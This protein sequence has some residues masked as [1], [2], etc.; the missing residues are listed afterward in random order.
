M[1]NKLDKRK[2]EICTATIT[3]YDDLGSRYWF[4]EGIWR[5]VEEGKISNENIEQGSWKRM[6]RGKS[7]A[8]RDASAS[9]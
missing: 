6:L 1:E 4:M 8:N 9:S 2:A 5:R 7:V 3:S